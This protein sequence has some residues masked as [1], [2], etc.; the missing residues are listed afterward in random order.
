MLRLAG[1]RLEGSSRM[2][3][4][5]KDSSFGRARSMEYYSAHGR[6]PRTSR[7]A[8]GRWRG[9]QSVEE[10]ILTSDRTSAEQISSGADLPEANLIGSNL[11]RANLS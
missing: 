11:V 4:E 10:Q 1:H 6:R 8:K 9:V 2:G 3:M 7:E 5:M